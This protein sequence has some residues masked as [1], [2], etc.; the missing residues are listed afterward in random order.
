ML[1][2]AY[3]DYNAT[4]PIRPEVM[5]AVSPFLKDGFA[6]PNS[7][8]RIGQEVRRALELARERVARLLGAK[9]PGEIVFTS[10]GSEANSAALYGAAWHSLQQSGR[11]KIIV[12][13][14]EHESMREILPILSSQGFKIYET[15]VDSNGLID[16][17]SLLEA[18]DERTALVS[19]M[20]ANNETGVI[21][22]IEKIAA[23]CRERGVLFHSDA[24]QSA[25]KIPLDVETLGVD[26]LSI[27][28]HKLGALKGAG[29]LYIRNGVKL[30]PLIAGLQEKRRRGGTENVIGIVALG[31]AAQLSLAE[32]SNSQR[33]LSWRRQIED[34]CLSASNVRLNGGEGPRLPNTSNFSIEG[35]DGH[36]LAIAFDLAGVCVSSGSACATGLS[37]PSHVL[38]AMG[39][40]KNLI[41]GA[42]R[43]STGW[44]TTQEEVDRFIEVFPRVVNKM[45]S[46]SL[47]PA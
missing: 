45:R 14:V 44:R 7:P 40:P 35:V 18:I 28:G 2:S 24:V 38:R 6:N 29:A 42:L 20:Q 47:V 36:S 13:A 37:S 25:G 32:L 43:V 30:F 16:D 10:S 3:L 4:A 9:N 31:V 27:S 41:K 21:Q 8:Y 22:P 46:V 12:S 19:V 23:V 11:N 5:G 17:G 1:E 26:L 33:Y 34:G 39:L 15:G